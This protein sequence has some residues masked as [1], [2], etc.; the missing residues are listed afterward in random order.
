MLITETI[1]KIGGKDHS[2]NCYLL[3]AEEELILIDTGAPSYTD[4]M[5]WEVKNAGLDPDRITRIINTH[6]HADHIGGNSL[7]KEK[8]NP[9]L[10]AHL[11][12]APHIQK[13]DEYTARSM[14]E[15]ELRGTK[16]TPIDE[17]FRIDG[18]NFKALHTPGHTLGSLCLYDPAA[19]IL[20]SGDTVFAQGFGRTDLPGGNMSNLQASLKKLS[21]LDVRL[22]LPGHGEHLE[23]RGD[24]AI[25]QALELVGGSEGAL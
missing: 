4:S 19:E 7:L 13:P 12:D 17:G 20:I 9:G 11:L 3:Q 14:V 5:L 10:F 25:T 24:E 15:G 8:F 6:C 18:T 23:R 1:H 2:S 16:V 21:E 22:L